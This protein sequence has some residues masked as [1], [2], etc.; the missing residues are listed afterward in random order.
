MKIIKLEFQ[1]YWYETFFMFK[2]SLLLLNFCL[3]VYTDEVQYWAECI[4]SHIKLCSRWEM[5]LQWSI[6]KRFRYIVLLFYI[7]MHDPTIYLILTGLRGAMYIDTN[8][9]RYSLPIDV[10]N[11]FWFHGVVGK[12]ASLVRG[13]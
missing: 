9:S 2:T 1:L 12:S 5:N 13:R 4:V 8:I 7:A 10:F 3:C 6:A 11:L